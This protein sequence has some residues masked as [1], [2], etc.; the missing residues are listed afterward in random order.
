MANK[1]I[2]VEAELKVED[3]K[4]RL[5]QVE[6]PQGLVPR[7]TAYIDRTLLD[8]YDMDTLQSLA[9]LPSTAF[10]NLF[11]FVALTQLKYYL[12]SAHITARRLYKNNGSVLSLPEFGT[13][14]LK[15][16]L[17]SHL[18]DNLQ[19]L[20][21]TSEQVEQ[22]KKDYEVAHHTVCNLETKLIELRIK[23]LQDRT[24]Y[25]VET[26][27]QQRI[28]DSKEHVLAIKH[29]IDAVSTTVQRTA[30][31]I[32]S[33]RIMFDRLQAQTIT[34][35][36]YALFRLLILDRQL[37]QRDREL[38][39][40]FRM[41]LQAGYPFKLL[42]DAF[43]GHKAIVFESL[44]SKAFEPKTA[45]AARP[46]KFTSFG[47]IHGLEHNLPLDSPFPLKPSQ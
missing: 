36:E 32:A 28:I 2:T 15:Y 18:T 19:R 10:T 43:A 30:Q 35:T 40:S 24:L 5:Y 14:A 29:N 20:C 38:L 42:F 6:I 47:S 13:W 33:L 4:Y 45:S 41:Y 22:L 9:T 12:A 34:S 21:V 7:D 37:I 1:T 25:S 8:Y 26:A 3:S 27:L 11:D 31:S 44:K 46:Y 17:P 39:E 16:P 23:K